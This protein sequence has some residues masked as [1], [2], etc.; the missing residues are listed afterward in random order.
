MSLYIT[1][2]KKGDPEIFFGNLSLVETNSEIVP[3]NYIPL[4][5]EAEPAFN[6]DTQ[7]LLEDVRFEDKG[8][9]KFF[10]VIPLSQEELDKAKEA[11]DLKNGAGTT[12]DRLIRLEKLM[13]LILSKL[14]I[15][16]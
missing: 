16:D 14:G 5:I 12:M 2:D 15:S 4:T 7:K 11:A 10:R 13:D 9:V 1:V 6:P 8:A 3:S